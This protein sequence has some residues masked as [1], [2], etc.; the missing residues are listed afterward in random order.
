MVDSHGIPVTVISGFLGSGKTTLLNRLLQAD[1]GL[2]ITVMVNDFG[3]ID[4][5]SQLL[6]SQDANSISLKNGCI[7]CSMQNDLVTEFQRL[8]AQP[9][10]PEY[11][12]VETSGVSD[13]NKVVSTLRYPQLRDH[14]HLETVVTLLNAETI[15]DTDAAL[16][17][18]L[19]SQL[20][21][22]DLMVIN[23]VDCVQQAQL[24]AIKQ[25]WLYPA[26]RVLETSYA[27]VPVEL[28]FGVGNGVG[29]EVKPAWSFTPVNNN[30]DDH[31]T[32]FQSWSWTSGQPLN[33]QQLRA[34]ITQLPNHIYR[35]KGIFYTQEKAQQPLLLQMAGP[36]SEWQL[37][38]VWT[39]APASQLVLIG[40]ANSLQP[41]ELQDLFDACRC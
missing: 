12:L 32:L 14:F 39:Q 22:A 1:H 11:I 20:D 27:D 16:K 41:D 33:L 10:R 19:M 35:V 37:L 5:D 31:Q 28:L 6:E 24:D 18:L 7:C 23:K 36:R 29:N 40:A 38:G 15:A 4:I 8:L 34:V 17:P 9:K 30:V 21:A 13:P 25:Q 26:A 2:Q 3:A